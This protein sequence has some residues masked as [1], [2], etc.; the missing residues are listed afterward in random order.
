MVIAQREW[1]KGQYSMEKQ[2]A[3]SHPDCMSAKSGENVTQSQPNQE[4]IRDCLLP[5]I[6]DGNCQNY[7]PFRRQP[8]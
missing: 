7:F 8:W 4:V 6:A 2:G 1:C 5:M 3:A